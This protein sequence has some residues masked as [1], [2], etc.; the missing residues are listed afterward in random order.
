MNSLLTAPAL[1]KIFLLIRGISWRRE[2]VW[3]ADLVRT[4]L[5][6]QTFFTI[7]SLPT[8][9]LGK[10]ASRAH[11]SNLP[12]RPCRVSRP[13]VKKSATRFLH[14]T[15]CKDPHQTREKIRVALFIEYSAFFWLIVWGCIVS[16]VL[17]HFR[18]EN[19]MPATQSS[20]AVRNSRVHVI[21][22]Q[23]RKESV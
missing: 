3:R 18:R 9:A 19:C 8:H 22:A 20:D 11:S 7:F 17:T 2:G 21:W 14:R 5:K 10:Q 12:L 23:R 15:P 16:C 13:G 4:E 1:A 6:T